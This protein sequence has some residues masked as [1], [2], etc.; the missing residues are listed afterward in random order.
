MA[1]PGKKKS[2][3]TRWHPSTIIWIIVIILVAIF[4]LY[5]FFKEVKN[6]EE[7]QKHIE[8]EHREVQQ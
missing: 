4:I 6:E 8:N 3:N 1:S 7:F 5:A 2:C